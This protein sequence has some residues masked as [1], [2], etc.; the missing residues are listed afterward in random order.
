MYN[1]NITMFDIVY[2]KTWITFR[3]RRLITE[4]LESFHVMPNPVGVCAFGGKAP[5]R[6]R[7]AD[8]SNASPFVQR[9]ISVY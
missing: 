4:L 2:E 1:V 8:S 5:L 9:R 7:W 3:R 6:D